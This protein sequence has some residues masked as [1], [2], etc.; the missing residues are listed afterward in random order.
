LLWLKKTENV[1]KVLF[2]ISV[3][4]RNKVEEV[5]LDMAVNMELIVKRSFS[6]AVR[7]IDRFHLQKLVL[8]KKVCP[9]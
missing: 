6:K 8:Y 5:T 3:G 9:K 1:I 7:V 4:K 2:K